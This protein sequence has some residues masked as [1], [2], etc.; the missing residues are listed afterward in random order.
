MDGTS[1]LTITDENNTSS[2]SSYLSVSPGPPGEQETAVNAELPPTIGP[3]SPANGRP[4]CTSPIATKPVVSRQDKNASH[5][6]RDILKTTSPDPPKQLFNLSDSQ[7]ITT[8]NDSK[9]HPRESYDGFALL[10]RDKPLHSRT[11]TTNSDFH[12]RPIA[13]EVGNDKRAA[14]PGDG[15]TI[16]DSP[17]IQF[18][19]YKETLTKDSGEIK[20]QLN[21]EGFPGDPTHFRM[22]NLPEQARVSLGEGQSLVSASCKQNGDRQD[23][24]ETHGNFSKF[25]GRPDERGNH[26]LSDLNKKS[27]IS[28]TKMAMVETKSA[29]ASG[30]TYWHKPLIDQIFITDVTTNFVTVTVKE[31]LTDKGFFKERQSNVV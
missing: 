13:D 4:D 28:D 1:D 2:A 27:P 10:S 7:T 22:G 20:G 9:P 14:L 5:N 19:H 31:C 29:A 18:R 21:F 8:E 26:L 30:L 15:A 24:I 25:P 12:L 23:G 16:Y 6:I 11:K 3:S 17:K